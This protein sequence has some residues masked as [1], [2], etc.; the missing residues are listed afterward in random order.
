MKSQKIVYNIK[1]AVITQVTRPPGAMAGKKVY[2][3]RINLFPGNILT[4]A[5][6]LQFAV[7]AQVAHLKDARNPKTWWPFN[8][9]NQIRIKG[10]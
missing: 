4:M 5:E 9:T 6:Q 3:L 10:Q 8:N 7:I 1:F 2:A